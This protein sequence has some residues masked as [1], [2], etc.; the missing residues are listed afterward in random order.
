MNPGVTDGSVDHHISWSGCLLKSESHCD[1]RQRYPSH[2]GPCWK[3]NP[4]VT[5]AKVNHHI[6]VRNNE[7]TKQ[8]KCETTKV[9]NNECTKQ[10]KYETTKL[11]INERTRLET[12]KGRCETAKVRDYKTPEGR[13]E[14]TIERC[15]TTRLRNIETAK[16]P[17]SDAKKQKGDAEGRDV[18]QRKCEMALYPDTIT[19]S[20]W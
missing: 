18:K 1:K 14:T 19:S 20:L 8:R 16:Q 9:R 6:R 7:C 2:Q 15:E 11:R 4:G 3:V 17:K 10:R 12:T 5:D 13:Y